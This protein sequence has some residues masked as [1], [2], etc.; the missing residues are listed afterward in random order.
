M[1][2]E[3]QGRR[4]FRTWVGILSVLIA[5]G[6]AV[7]GYFLLRQEEP[8]K[9]AGPV[10]KVTVAAAE[11]L[12]GAL[13]YVAEDQRFFEENGLD[14]T[15]RGYG[16]G[17][18]CADALIN[19]EADICTSA[20]FVFVSNSSQHVDL[21]VFG[22][23]ATAQ[24]KELIVRKDRGITT[25]DD[26]AGKRIGVTR[27][28]GAE[29]LLGVFLTLN[30]LSY[31]TVELVDLKPSEIVEAISDGD[32][33]AAFTWDPYS[34]DIKKELGEN[35]I[36]W[37]GGEE[38]YFLLL[39][40]RDWIEDNP[41]AAERFIESLLEA[42]EYIEDNSEKVK[43]FVKGRFD[44]E[45]DYIEYSWPRQEFAVI[46]EQAML[47]TFEDQARWRIENNLTDKTQIP[48]YLNFIYWDALEAAKPE[49]VTVIR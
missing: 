12:A 5:L 3:E 17:K 6:L 31:E 41:A 47:I 25:I 11:Y 37:F 43:E 23:V 48:N 18:A 2:G 16:S 21:R 14:V 9:Y 30:G 20:G 10:D 49:A 29:F 44:Y 26:L 27:R 32:I 35:V 7:G 8:G 15:I 42:E 19:R 24:V 33:D 4:R 13:I 28:S 45:A 40:Q 34:Y 36:S 38:F 46:L 39:A 1:A 22:T